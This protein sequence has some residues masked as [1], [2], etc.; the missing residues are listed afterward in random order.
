MPISSVWEA[1]PKTPWTFP[2]LAERFMKYSLCQSIL[3]LLPPERH[4]LGAV[5]G[6]NRCQRRCS[7]KWLRSYHEQFSTLRRGGVVGVTDQKSGAFSKDV[8]LDRFT[9][10]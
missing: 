1:T 10:G 5:A 7:E 9:L 4:R 2:A 6:C 3:P 8:L